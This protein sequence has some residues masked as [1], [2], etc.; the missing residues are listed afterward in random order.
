MKRPIEIN[1]IINNIFLITIINKQIAKRLII[2]IN[3]NKSKQI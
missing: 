1:N 3:N 2:K